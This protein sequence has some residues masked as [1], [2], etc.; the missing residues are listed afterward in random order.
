MIRGIICCALGVLTFGIGLES[1]W[2][3]S[4]DKKENVIDVESSCPDKTE[5]VRDEAN[6][7]VK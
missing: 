3:L 5:P 4:K 7:E 2:K 6:G 1:F